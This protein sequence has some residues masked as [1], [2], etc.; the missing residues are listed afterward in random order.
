MRITV[1]CILMLLFCN[2]DLYAQRDT[3]KKRNI[4]P[5]AASIIADINLMYDN[6][7]QAIELEYAKLVRENKTK[8]DELNDKIKQMDKQVDKLKE[9]VRKLEEVLAKMEELMPKILRNISNDRRK[10]NQLGIEFGQPYQSGR[11][12]SMRDSIKQI[13][14]LQTTARKDSLIRLTQIHY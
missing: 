2:L 12:I 9:Q 11:L 8:T 10:A 7:E 5:T 3:T 13:L 1:A 6:L 14:P 4:Q